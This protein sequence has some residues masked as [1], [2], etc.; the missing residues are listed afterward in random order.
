MNK[1]QLRWFYRKDSIKVEDSWYLYT[2]ADCF[3]SVSTVMYKREK[4]MYFIPLRKLQTMNAWIKQISK[5]CRHKCPTK[6]KNVAYNLGG[7]NF[8]LVKKDITNYQEGTYQVEWLN[9]VV[10]KM[11]LKSFQLHFTLNSAI[12][13]LKIGLI[14]WKISRILRSIHH[15]RHF[16]QERVFRAQLALGLGVSCDIRE[17]APFSRPL[18][19]DY[20]LSF[21]IYNSSRLLIFQN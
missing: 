21:Q 1:N 20:I 14:V 18:R 6:H 7:V 3:Q 10:V 12:Y 9:L 2:S 5:I 16:E 11:D 17:S 4:I 13:T 15:F 8:G 19:Y